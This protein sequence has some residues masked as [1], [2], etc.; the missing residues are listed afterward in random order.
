LRAQRDTD[1]R[2]AKSLAEEIELRVAAWLS[3]N[4]K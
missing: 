2:L 4:K 1:I 3:D